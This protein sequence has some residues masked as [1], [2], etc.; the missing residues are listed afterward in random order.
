[1][2][3]ARLALVQRYMVDADEEETAA[4]GRIEPVAADVREQAQREAA[5]P[6][7]QRSKTQRR[8]RERVVAD[9][10]PTSEAARPVVEEMLPPAPTVGPNVP[11]YATADPAGGQPQPDLRKEARVRKAL[12]K[13]NKRAARRIAALEKKEAR[14]MKALAKAAARRRTV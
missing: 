6:R 3:E 11:P 13:A 8:H 1:L 5:G 2:S 10:I 7:R 4:R 12:A 9:A 14:E